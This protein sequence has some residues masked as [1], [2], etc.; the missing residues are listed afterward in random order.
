MLRSGRRIAVAMLIGGL[1]RRCAALFLALRFASPDRSTDIA[2]LF[3]QNP[4]DYALS[5]ATFL[6]CV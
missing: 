6:I 3:R 4:H 5:S 2:T 1:R